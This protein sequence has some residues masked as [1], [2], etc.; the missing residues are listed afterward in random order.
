MKSRDA[1]PDSFEYKITIQEK[2]KRKTIVVGDRSA[3][4][5]L[6]HLIDYLVEQSKK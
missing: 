6:K 4:A 1:M 3:P 5:N 2:G